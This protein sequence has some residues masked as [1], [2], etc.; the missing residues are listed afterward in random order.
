MI[1]NGKKY[2]KD[3]RPLVKYVTENREELLNSYWITVDPGSHASGYCLMRGT[4]VIDNNEFKAKASD[5]IHKRLIH[6]YKF[7]SEAFGLRDT[8]Q[9]KLLLIEKIRGSRTH[10]FLPFSIGTVIAACSSTDMI[11]CPTKVWHTLRSKDYVKTDKL[12][13]YLMAQVVVE[14][15]NDR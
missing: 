1:I 14:I 3:V 5:P 7:Y 4:T 2:P 13:A 8:P 12:D 11:E 15:L 9:I 6:I 10:A